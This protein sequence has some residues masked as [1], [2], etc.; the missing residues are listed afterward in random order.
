MQEHLAVQENPIP[1]ITPLEKA[2]GLNPHVQ[3]AEF[4]SEQEHERV[5]GSKGFSITQL[6]AKL[7]LSF[8]VFASND[9]FFN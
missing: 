8:F 7:C 3:M 1:T 5:S 6:G 2:P 9:F 4:G